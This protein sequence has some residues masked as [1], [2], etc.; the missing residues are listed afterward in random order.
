MGSGKCLVALSLGGLLTQRSHSNLD[1]MRV[2]RV[3]LADANLLLKPGV[4]L[5]I[6]R[7]GAAFLGLVRL[8]L[9]WSPGHV[10]NRAGRLS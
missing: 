7:D 6:D 4:E 10:S 8:E 3:Q 5:W 2:R 9:L 1:C